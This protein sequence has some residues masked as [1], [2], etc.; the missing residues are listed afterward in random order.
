MCVYCE[1]NENGKRK[2]LFKKSQRMG[3]KGTLKSEAIIRRVRNSKKYSIEVASWTGSYV[4]LLGEVI[5]NYCPVCGREVNKKEKSDAA[6]TLD[7]LGS[8]F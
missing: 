4:H 3:S 5:C 1:V 8:D 7:M 2:K 6:K